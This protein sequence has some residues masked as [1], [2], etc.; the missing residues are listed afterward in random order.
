MRGDHLARLDLPV[1]RIP[2]Q[3][4]RSFR[5]TLDRNTQLA[6]NSRLQEI[7]ERHESFSLTTSKL[8]STRLQGMPALRMLPHRRLK[9]LLQCRGEAP[10]AKRLFS[11][12]APFV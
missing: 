10:F 6:I 1:C 9:D 4:C 5:L 7:Y 11:R 2:L 8:N 12:L 3:V